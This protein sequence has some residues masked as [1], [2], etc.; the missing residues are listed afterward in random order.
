M[1]VVAALLALTGLVPARAA[2]ARLRVVSLNVLHGGLASG[3]VGDG[4]RLEE[5][6]TMIRDG[7]GALEADVIGLQEAS[8]GPGRGNV[9]RRLARALGVDVVAAPVMSR[10]FLG[11]VAAAVLRLDEGPAVLSRFPIAASETVPLPCG[12]PFARLLLCAEIAAPGGPIDVCATH[13]DGTPCQL[14][15][16]F[17][18]LRRRRRPDRALVVLGDLNA[19]PEHRGIRRLLSAGF[20]DALAVADARVS[21]A[22]VWQPVRDP[23][24]LARR[25]VD[26]VLVA[27]D[28]AVRV[29]SSRLVLDAPGRGADGAALWP[30]DHYGVLADLDLPPRHAAGRPTPRVGREAWQARRQREMR[31]GGFEPPRVLPH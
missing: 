29:V 22:T 26:Y 23:R 25:R 2:A 30:S 5:R 20:L 4:E 3:L 10:T 18:A 27:P 15:G 13:V 28:D 14:A 24:R 12:D 16:L 1:A 17:E 6:L 9:A 8:A 19:V 21:G 7:L 31:G 11:W